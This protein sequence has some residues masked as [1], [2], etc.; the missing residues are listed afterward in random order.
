MVILYSFVRCFKGAP[1]VRKI[2]GRPAPQVGKGVHL[3]MSISLTATELQTII[4]RA[5]AEARAAGAPAVPV[6]GSALPL[7]EIVAAGPPVAPP[8]PG[9]AQMAAPPPPDLVR[10]LDN[11][12]KFKG[13]KL[14]KYSLIW[15]MVKDTYE[16][17][18]EGFAVQGS[19]HTTT[20]GA[21]TYF[22]VKYRRITE[23]GS[24]YGKSWGFQM[25]IYGSLRF[26][27]FRAKSVDVFYFKEQY[28]DVWV[29]YPTPPSSVATGYMMEE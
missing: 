23:D 17:D 22:S 11:V 8:P 13:N 7:N 27:V 6:P 3:K 4:A 9:P 29:Q 16:R 12:M 14:G 15:E 18:P 28:E 2:E 5:I 25:H 10:T 1:G 19:V 20:D 21:R 24:P 26:N